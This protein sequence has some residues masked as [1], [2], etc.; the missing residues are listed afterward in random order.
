MNTTQQQEVSSKPLLLNIT[1]AAQMLGLGRTKMYE[2]IANEGL[3]TVRFG[4]AIRVPYSSLQGWI[5]Q[6]EEQ[7]GSA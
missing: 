4:R 3:P 2:L 7:G 5:K 6:R 1:Q